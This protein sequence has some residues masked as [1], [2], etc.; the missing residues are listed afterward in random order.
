M[1]LEEAKPFGVSL[2]ELLYNKALYLDSELR[3]IF[4]RAILSLQKGQT[5]T[6]VQIL[7]LFFELLK[8]E[9]KK[10]R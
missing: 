1:I 7:T 5:L 3:I 6:S 9:D 4:C 8:C 10:L 2:I